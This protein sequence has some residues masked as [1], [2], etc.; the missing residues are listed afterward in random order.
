MGVPSVGDLGVGGDEGS[1]LVSYIFLKYIILI[2][3]FLK[4]KQMNFFIK[5]DKGDFYNE[6]NISF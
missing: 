3:Y 5:F 4:N 6:Y 1:I 2:F